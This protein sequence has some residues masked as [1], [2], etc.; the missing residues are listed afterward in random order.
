MRCRQLQNM[1]GTIR[2]TVRPSVRAN[3]GLRRRAGSTAS[4]RTRR[5]N[6]RNSGTLPH[7]LRGA[8]RPELCTGMGTA[9]RPA[10]EV[11]GLKRRFASTASAAARAK[12]AER[13]TCPARPHHRRVSGGTLRQALTGRPPASAKRSH[14]SRTAAAAGPQIKANSA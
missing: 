12:A 6:L 13:V 9:R 8:G 11:S 1:P 7:A 2:A 14:Q 3:A 5:L 10:T 4:V